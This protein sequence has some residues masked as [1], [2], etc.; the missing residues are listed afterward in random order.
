MEEKYD[1][2]RSCFKNKQKCTRIKCL[3]SIDGGLTPTSKE[4]AFK[5]IWIFGLL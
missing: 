4:S 3:S 1:V 2:L 5:N